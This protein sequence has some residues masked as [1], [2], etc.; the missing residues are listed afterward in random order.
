LADATRHA[1]SG[2]ECPELK[3]LLKINP[4]Q[5][6]ATRSALGNAS[7]DL[8]QAKTVLGI[9]VTDSGLT[10]EQLNAVDDA[11]RRAKQFTNDAERVVENARRRVGELRT[12]ADVWTWRVAVGVTAACLLAAVGQVFLARFCWRTFRG[13]PA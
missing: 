10:P 3:R 1:I 5:V 13:Q 11:L 2:D 9:P 8:R 7:A 4:E 6:T 12:L